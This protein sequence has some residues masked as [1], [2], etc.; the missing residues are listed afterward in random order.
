MGIST[1]WEPGYVPLE[2]ISLECT[3]QGTMAAEE[4]ITIPRRI[5]Y[6]GISGLTWPPFH[7]PA[8][9]KFFSCP[10]V[11][12]LTYQAALVRQ[13]EIFA[14]N[15][16]IQHDTSTGWIELVLQGQTQA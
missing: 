4:P 6:R 3:A 10:I 13:A 7:P 5:N 14:F 1:S 8:L 15:P 12:Q 11:F 9:G 16:S 2:P